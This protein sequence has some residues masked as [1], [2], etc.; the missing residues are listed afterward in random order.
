MV[1]SENKSHKKDSGRPEMVGCTVENVRRMTPTSVLVTLN[2]GEHLPRFSHKP[3]QR[4]TFCLELGDA[5]AYRSYNLVNSPGELPCIAVKNVATGGGSEFFNENVEA[6]D[7]VRVSIPDGDIYDLA[8]DHTAHHIML[9]AAGSGITPLISI[10]NHALTARPD[11]K[12]TLIYANSSA[13]DI[14]MQ[15]KLEEMAQS[16]RFEVFHVLGDGATGEDLS[17]G[18]LDGTKLQHL[19]GQFRRDD[20]PEMGF[21]SG[22]AGFME[23]VLEVTQQQEKPLPVVPYSFQRQPYL[24]PENHG[25]GSG[26]STVQLSVNGLIREIK[27]PWHQTLLKSADAAGIAMPANCR[28]GI[29]HRCKARLVAGHTTGGSSPIP[30]KKVP[31]GWILCCQQRPGSDRIEIEMD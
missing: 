1:S 18:R 21:L 22:P 24:N 12:V 10:A 14:M 23:L 25:H 13:R 15:S 4:V 29:C 31:E 19:L 7:S 16:N 30:G 11:H 20:I 2:P 5:P 26:T 27:A 9:F 8:T 3:G 28:S 17:T 6:G